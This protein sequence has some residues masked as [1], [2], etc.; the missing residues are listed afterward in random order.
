MHCSGNIG[1]PGHPS[2]NSSDLIVALATRHRATAYEV[3]E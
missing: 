2:N 1:L 3:I